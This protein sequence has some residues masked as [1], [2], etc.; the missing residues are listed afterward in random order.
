MPKSLFTGIPGGIDYALLTC[1]KQG[2]LAWGV[3]KNVNRHLNV[4]MRG[5]FGAITGFLIVAAAFATP[6]GFADNGQRIFFVFFGLHAYWNS[7]YFGW[8][9]VDADSRFRAKLSMANQVA[10][11]KETT[12][13]SKA[14]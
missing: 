3:E 5:P 7:A 2:W 13:K 6:Q 1:C 9:A 4:W 8:H 12:V 11:A 10:Q 14:T